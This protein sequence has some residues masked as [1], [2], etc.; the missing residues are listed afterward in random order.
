MRSFKV[1]GV[2]LAVRVSERGR[3]IE[4][5]WLFLCC[6]KNPWRFAKDF[7]GLRSDGLTDLDAISGPRNA[8]IAR[9]SAFFFGTNGDNRKNAVA[10]DQYSPT[11]GILDELQYYWKGLRIGQNY[12]TRRLA[13]EERPRKTYGQALLAASKMQP[14]SYSQF[15]LF[16]IRLRQLH[17]P[18][19]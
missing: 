5:I 16:K 10:H 2:G 17:N 15:P 4:F 6:V 11:E 3:W 8:E 7:R 1:D 14:L 13:A 18:T 19:I 9:S 12:G